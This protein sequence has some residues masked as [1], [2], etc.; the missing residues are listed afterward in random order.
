[1]E[2][3][4]RIKKYDWECIKRIGQEYHHLER[5]FFQGTNKE[6]EVVEELLEEYR[7]LA[8]LKIEDLKVDS[9]YSIITKTK[10]KVSYNF[11]GKTYEAE[12]TNFSEHYIRIEKITEK[13]IIGN[14]GFTKIKKEDLYGVIE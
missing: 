1:M 3:L 12:E 5:G 6:S 2:N 4:I 9:T 8:Y 13:F 10:N 14:N 7:L 11:S